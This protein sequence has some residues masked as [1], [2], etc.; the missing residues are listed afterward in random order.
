[1]KKLWNKII[2]LII[3]S[4]GNA[5]SQSLLRELILNPQYSSRIVEKVGRKCSEDLI[6]FYKNDNSFISET[7]QSTLLSLKD[8]SK[9]DSN[10]E[11]VRLNITELNNGFYTF[12]HYTNA[13]DA[14]NLKFEMDNLDRDLVHQ[15]LLDGSH[16]KSYAS[17]SRFLKLRPFRNLFDIGKYINTSKG[18]LYLSSCPTCS[19]GFGSYQISFTFDPNSKVMLVDRDYNWQHVKDEIFSN[20]AI[21]TRH[22][23][24]EKISL[25]I[26]E[27][28]K[29]DLVK[30]DRTW[31]QL[32]SIDKI[33]NSDMIFANSDHDQETNNRVKNRRSYSLHLK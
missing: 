5:Y 33:L 6:D 32:I 13:V 27:D 2:I 11:R 19:D 22:C 26:L 16:D 29:V 1:M 4:S 8:I 15:K 25:F 9:Y 12:F 31:Y 24:F 7:I 3:L 18:V 20:Y 30:Y 10:L 28:N 23:D 21:V 14:F 17:I